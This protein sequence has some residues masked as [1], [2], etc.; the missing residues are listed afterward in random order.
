MPVYNDE[1]Y[2]SDSLDS[3]LRQSFKDI[4]VICINDGSTDNSLNILTNYKDKF[5]WMKIISQ[6]NQGSGIARNVGIKEATGEYLSFLDSDDIFVD[7]DAL[8]KMYNTAI[9]YNSDMVS[10][11]LKGIT[12]NGDLVNNDNL[13]RFD[14]EKIISPEEYEI[15]Y[16]FYKNIIKKSFLIDN[17]IKFPNLKRGQDPVFLAEVLI[18]LKEIPVVP[19]DLYGFRYAINGGLSKINTYEKKRDYL[20]HFKETFDILDSAN[21]NEM[22][23]AYEDKLKLYLT[24]PGNSE[25]TEL[26]EIVK[27]VFKEHDSILDMCYHYLRLDKIKI[28]VIVPVYNAEKF[29]EESISSVLNQT[30]KDIEIICVNDG[31]K[32]NSLQMLNEFARKDTRVK[33]FDKEN[34]GCGSARNFGLERA[35][36]RYVYFFDPDDYILPNAFEKLYDNAINNDSDLVLFKIARFRDGEEVD[37]SIPGFDFDNVFTNVNFNSFT[38]NYKD[39]KSYVLNSSFAPW[40]KLYKKEFLDKYNDFRFEVGVAFDDVPFHVQTLLRAKKMSFVPE[41]FYHYRLSNPNSVNNTKSNQ[42]GIIKICNIVYNFLLNEGYYDEFKDEFLLFKINQLLNYIISSNSVSYFD[43]VK[44]EFKNMDFS[45]K[46]I[47]SSLLKKV[48]AVLYSP[49]YQNYRRLILDTSKK[50]VSVIIPVYNTEKYLSEC[51]DSIISQTLKEI[52]ILV[53][54]DGSDDSSLSILEDY[55]DKDDRIKIFSKEHGGAGSARNIGL[56][57]CNAEYINFVDSDDWLDKNCLEEVYTCCKTNNM[58]IVMYL[59]I[60]TESNGKLY[61]TDYY[62]ISCIDKKLDKIFTYNNVKDVIFDIPVSPCNKLIRSSLI[63]NLNLKFIEGL[64]FEDNPFFFRLFLNSK[65]NSIIRK[66]FYFRRRHEKSIMNSKNMKLA[67]IV[68]ITTEIIKIFNE[69]GLY[70]E[71]K[72][73]L[74]NFKLFSIRTYYKQLSNEI[75][76]CYYFNIMKKDFYNMDDKLKQDFNK[77]LYSDTSTFFNNVLNSESYIDFDLR[78]DLYYLQIRCNNLEKENLMV[79]DINKKLKRDFNSLN[80]DFNNNFVNEDLLNKICYLR[81]ENSELKIK[82]RVYMDKIKVL[83]KD[84]LF[85]KNKLSNKNKFF[86]NFFKK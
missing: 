73:L 39:V 20:L 76:K 61:E 58:D 29:L 80:C 3:I 86:N 59:L 57:Y 14:E 27:L 10:A 81:N 31:S 78:M 17:K 25:D 40:T 37:Y 19:I 50:K 46:N 1:K 11:N 5:K 84:I 42:I 51:L 35:K 56:N 83:Q 71:F 77:Y 21:F 2:L 7:K 45:S 30:L 13:K 18:N 33:V 79:D 82:N 34:G 23:T 38:F 16:S 63:S 52:E 12:V 47:S 66:H 60:N 28:S 75:D 85:L 62:N 4:E 55:A 54:D 48:N 72:T 43:N 67:D 44:K 64:M 36:G 70:D 26:H 41:F 9:K 74:P 22:K 8:L 53:I 24:Y 65:R 68:P 49:S 15:P 32:D 69:Y 6:E